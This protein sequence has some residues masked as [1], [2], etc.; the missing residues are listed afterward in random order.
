MPNLRLGLGLSQGNALQN[1]PILDT[2]SGAVFASGYTKFKKTATKSCRVR[3]D[4]DNTELDIGFIGKS[5][6][7]VA[8]ES[9]VNPSPITYTNGI[10][11]SD[12]RNGTTS[13]STQ[14]A[15]VSV[16]NNIATILADGTGIDPKII[17][18]TSIV[19]NT[20]S[21]YYV[22]AK[23]K[24]TNSVCVLLAVR[25]T[26]PGMV[27]IEATQ[28]SPVNGT[29]YSI[30]G[31]VTT[32]AGG[33]GNNVTMQ[34]KH[35]YATLGD[36]NG[37][38][39]DIQEIMVFNLTALGI[40]HLTKTQCDRIFSYTYTTNTVAGINSGYIVKEYDQV[41]SNDLVQA[42][43]TKQPRIVNEGILE[44]TVGIDTLNLKYPTF[45]SMSGVNL[46]SNG[47]FSNGTTGWNISFATGSVSN[48]T[49]TL[50]GLGT[51]AQIQ[52]YQNIPI[53]SAS[54]A[55]KKYKVTC[56]IKVISGSP[57]Y[58]RVSLGDNV[59]G[60]APTGS[61]TLNTLNNPTIGAEYVLSVNGSVVSTFAGSLRAYII[62]DYASSGA[63]NNAVTEI[64]ETSIVDV[65]SEG[66]IAPRYFATSDSI[67]EAPY[68]AVFNLANNASIYAKHNPITT[69]GGAFGR[70]IV[71][72]DV[73]YGIYVTPSGILNMGSNTVSPSNTYVIGNNNANVG[74]VDNNTVGRFYLNGTYIGE[75]NTP[76]AIVQGTETLCKGN[77]NILGRGY[78][79]YLADTIIFN[80]VLTESEIKKLK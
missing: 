77:R 28:S 40:A 38:T 69:G 49:L 26:T 9:F 53:T 21:K 39:C 22:K 3:R 25:L 27:T 2:I 44:R 45:A 67:L 65:T 56:K 1:K 34:F 68:N 8:L 11:N 29:Q 80:R 13:W 6:D 73:H 37:K 52:S 70:T 42:T 12:F 15:S 62:V 58:I 79:G 41:N 57:T 30:S 43:T 35:Q 14:Y 76:Q 48:N 5:L 50:T 72:G 47:D 23:M 46:V 51:G 60:Q 55:N 64:K 4:S 75:D 20:G 7:R 16:T 31:I 66:T 78:D 17:Q 10:T 74:V 24:V 33:N 61:E 71:K 36:A 19:N 18:T 32:T 63:A 54:A 59:T